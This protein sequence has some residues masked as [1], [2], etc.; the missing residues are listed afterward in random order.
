MRH[1]RASSQSL[2][3][4][5]IGPRRSRGGSF[6][7]ITPPCLARL[8]RLAVICS[9][10]AGSASPVTGN[11]VPG[12]LARIDVGI[13]ADHTLLQPAIG[14]FPQDRQDRLLFDR[15]ALG[16]SKVFCPLSTDDRLP[17][18][19]SVDRWHRCPT[20]RESN[21]KK[22][23]VRDP[24]WSPFA[25]AG[26]PSPHRNSSGY[27]TPHGTAAGLLSI[28]ADAAAVA[29]KA[30]A[31]CPASK[32]AQRQRHTVSAG[33][34]FTMQRAWQRGVRPVAAH[35][36]HSRAAGR[37]LR[38]TDIAAA[39]PDARRPPSAPGFNRR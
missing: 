4:G 33:S 14:A 17:H 10:R 36:N 37:A 13:V 11:H 35:R 3:K 20:S 30:R 9:C 21:P 34:A 25:R 15:L 22:I 12:V 5:S 19:A 23:A 16:C 38:N 31:A 24:D 28:Y 32:F 18:S 2:A 27:G 7:R 29:G 8:A 26:H 1:A 6:A 39:R